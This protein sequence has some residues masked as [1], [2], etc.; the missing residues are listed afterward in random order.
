MILM[1]LSCRE[2]HAAA[3]RSTLG[4]QNCKKMRVWRLFVPKESLP[5]PQASCWDFRHCLVRYYWS[6]C[7][8]CEESGTYVRSWEFC[9]IWYLDVFGSEYLHYRMEMWSVC[10]QLL[11]L[12]S[13]LRVLTGAFRGWYSRPQAR[14][15][16]DAT[17]Q[18]MANVKA[19]HPNQKHMKHFYMYIL[20]ITHT[21]IY[22]IYLIWLY[23]I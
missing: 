9:W 22:L 4:S 19:W 8:T 6:P 11:E 16:W 20:Y 12:R 1:P 5:L 13:L 10:W 17:L 21:Y 2:V 15:D 7:T 3:E 14:Q 18:S 23:L